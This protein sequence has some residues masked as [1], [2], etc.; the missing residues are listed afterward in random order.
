M[1]ELQGVSKY[2]RSK[3]ALNGV[4]LTLPRG[5]VIGLV[6]ENGSGKTTMLKML[7]GILI[8]TT[9]F[10]ILD[11]N[12]ITRRVASSVAYM[13]DTDLFYPYFTVKQLFEFY[14]SQY[15]D[16]NMKKAQEIAEYL[17]ISLDAK[18]STLSKGNRG[19]VKIAATLG[20]DAAYY[21]LDE[22]FS[23]LDPMVRE[24]IARGLIRFTDT[25]WQTI[26]LSTHEIKEVEP[27]LDELIVLKEGQVLAHKE[28]DEIRDKYGIDATAWMISLFR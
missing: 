21:L 16:F 5:K 28:I 18:I 25:E 24:D 6:G 10:A 19:R 8:P 13:P 26:L 11:N 20:R 2:Y 27:L 23:G 9:G 15:E 12:K 7:A 14:D 3:R 17:V 1:I 4:S 22:P